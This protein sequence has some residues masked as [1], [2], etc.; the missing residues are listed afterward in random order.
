MI[1]FLACVGVPRNFAVVFSPL[2][3]SLPN[4]F[5]M[6]LSNLNLVLVAQ[7]ETS[8]LAAF[9]ATIATRTFSFFPVIFSPGCSNSSNCFRPGIFWNSLVILPALSF[10]TCN[11]DWIPIRVISLPVGSGLMPEG[12]AIGAS[13]GGGSVGGGVTDCGG[14]DSGGITSSDTSS[15]IIG[16]TICFLIV[17][18]ASLILARSL[19]ICSTLSLIW[20]TVMP[21]LSASSSRT[22]VIG[23]LL[24][25]FVPFWV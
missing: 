25:S 22:L 7:T 11:C 21:H 1:G 16:S 12:V 8:L 14:G 2:T 3:V 19:R 9:S 15:G 6:S 23:I 13:G 5:R 24:Y 20:S 17:A 10:S 4:A 18:S